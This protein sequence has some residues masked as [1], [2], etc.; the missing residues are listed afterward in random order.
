[1]TAVVDTLNRVKSGDFDYDTTIQKLVTDHT[2]IL[3]DIE[4]LNWDIAYHHLLFGQT[5]DGEAEL[6]TLMSLNKGEIAAFAA[7]L[8]RTDRLVLGLKGNKRAIDK[9]RDKLKA[10][11]QKLDI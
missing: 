4:G 8:F 1:M 2:E 11:L 5:R 3:D 10:I 6:K 9:N 7:E